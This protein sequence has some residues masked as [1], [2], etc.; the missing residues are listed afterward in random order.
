MT[1][2]LLLSLVLSLAFVGAAR[3][4]VAERLSALA[5][6]ESLRPIHPGVPG[7]SPFWNAGAKQFIF[8]PAFDIAAVKGAGCYRFTLV[9]ADGTSHSFEAGE[10]W[11]R[12]TPVWKAL[13]VGATRLKVEALNRLGGEV[14]AVAGEREF[15]RA[16]VFNGPYGKPVMPYEQSA[17]IALA[18]VV[19]EPFVQHWLKTGRPDPQYPLYRY[20]SKIIGKLLTACA[21]YARQSPRPDDADELLEIARRAADYLIDISMP[22][23][24]PL[25]GMPPTYHDAA[26]TERENDHWTMMM[27]P[28]EAGRGYLDLYDATGE[29]KYLDAARRIADAY[30]RLQLPSGT[31]PL[32]VDN[33]TNQPLAAIDLIPAEVIEFL[34][35]PVTGYQDES[36]QP[37]LDR[38]VR[39]MMEEPMRTFNWQAQFDDAKLR[40]AYENLAKHEACMFA[41]YLFRH[42]RKDARRI[43]MAGEL[44]RFAEDQFVIWEP[45]P[46]ASGNRFEDPGQWFYPC[47]AEQYAMFEPISGSSAFMIIAYVRAYEATGDALHLA[48]AESLANALTEAQ[49]HYHGRYPTRMYRNRDRT[50]WLNST[51][52]T[53]RAMQYLAEHTQARKRG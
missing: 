24:G 26:S 47:S 4:A 20:S 19:H 6:D 35:R 21:L 40:G 39:W 36:Y 32:K 2:A 17:R 37:A 12:L 10:P 34:D 33:R 53:I 14:V 13:P 49:A 29:A 8:A 46:P 44:L 43:E 22:A 5:I 38:A 48:K 25:E 28:A 7:K 41:A 3:A 45:P 51:V 16:A 18:G 52:N 9:S 27:T 30:A 23:G 31:W 50:Y 15:H 42:A 1:R 11:A